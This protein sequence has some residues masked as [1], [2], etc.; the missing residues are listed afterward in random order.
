M[1]RTKRTV[2]K[3][4]VQEQARQQRD[5]QPAPEPERVSEP[6]PVPEPQPEVLPESQPEPQPEPQAEPRPDPRPEPEPGGNG[7]S[8]DRLCGIFRVLANPVALEILRVLARNEASLS[9][10]A[11]EADLAPALVAMYVSDLK[12]QGIAA[13]TGEPGSARYNLADER[14]RSILAHVGVLKDA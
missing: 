4:A 1:G 13:K 14:V 2:R 8:I 6:V 9:E 11:G 5:G 12:R 10:I 7:A 3:K